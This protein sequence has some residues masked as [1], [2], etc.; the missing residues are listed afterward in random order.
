MK[1]DP[2]SSLA[3]AGPDPDQVNRAA[4][5][6]AALLALEAGAR[7]C[8]SVAELA[9][10]IA[11]DTRSVLRCGQVVAFRREGHRVRVTAVSGVSTVE[12]TAPFIQ[13]LEHAVGQ[14]SPA[15]A[16]SLH[17]VS[18]LRKGDP[19]RLADLA[20]EHLALVTFRTRSGRPFGGMLLARAEPWADREAPLLDR[21]RDTYA[22]AWMALSRRPERLGRVPAGRLFFPAAVALLV[23]AGFV[24]VPLTALA[25]VE[26]VARDPDVA[27]APLDGVIHSIEVEPNQRVE[28]GDVLVRFTDTALRARLAVAERSVEVAQARERRLGQAAFD[29]RTARRELAVASAELRLAVAERDAAAELLSRT[30][31][32]AGR[33]GVAIFGSRKDW[34][35]RPVSVG[36]RILQVASPEAV[37]LRIEMPVKDAILVRETASVRVYLDSD[38]LRPLSATLDRAT[39]HASVQPGGSLAFTLLALVDD[40]TPPPRIGYRGT[41]QVFGDDVALWYYLLRRPLTAMRQM[42]GL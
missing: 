37:Q 41:A 22:H 25:P 5:A 27:A 3:P 34:E 19:S 17:P 32:R 39:Y 8:G 33:A 35:G 2:V 20:F 30:V 6:Y 42:V 29:D 13:E 9:H 16:V 31:L 14:L 36:E 23:L 28:A 26:V 11:N 10:V 24:R 4:A 21:L 12:R 15:G 40:A 7:A 1:I 18:D 38:P